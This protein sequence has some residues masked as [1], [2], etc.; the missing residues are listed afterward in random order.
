MFM[1]E[2]QLFYCCVGLVTQYHDYMCLKDS[3]L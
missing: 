1:V 3:G 2:L